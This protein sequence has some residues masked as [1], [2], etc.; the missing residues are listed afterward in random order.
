MQFC[1]PFSLLNLTFWMWLQFRALREEKG[2]RR[3]TSSAVYECLVPP[4]CPLDTQSL[5]CQFASPRRWPHV[6]CCLAGLAGAPR[7]DLACSSVTMGCLC[8]PPVEML[9]PSHLQSPTPLAPM[10]SHGDGAL[11][12]GQACPWPFSPARWHFT[13]GAAMG[14]SLRPC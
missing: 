12:A 2:L 8:S 6:A 7:R 9:T 1:I 11:G 10:T 3:R 14:S 4:R 5:A 13:L